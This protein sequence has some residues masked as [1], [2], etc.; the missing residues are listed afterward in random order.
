MAFLLG[1]ILDLI[2][3]HGVVE[4]QAQADG[5]CGLHVLLADLVRLAVGLL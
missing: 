1:Y 4:G 5:M 3:E 2:V